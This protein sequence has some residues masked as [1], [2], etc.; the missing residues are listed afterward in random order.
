MAT[1]GVAAAVTECSLLELQNL[2]R[3][4]DELMATLAILGSDQLDIQAR[5][6]AN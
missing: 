1:Q 2:Q 6:G 3:R 5:L 4:A